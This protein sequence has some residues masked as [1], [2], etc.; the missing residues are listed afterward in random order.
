MI[1]FIGPANC[2]IP[3]T[4][5][6]PRALPASVLRP[7]RLLPPAPQRDGRSDDSRL[8][9]IGPLGDKLGR[10][11]GD[12]GPGGSGAAPQPGL[13]SAVVRPGASADPPQ[14][15]AG[16][17]AGLA[18][19]PGPPAAPAAA[20][21][22]AHRSAAPCRRRRPG[23]APPGPCS[24]ARA[25]AAGTRGLSALL[26]PLPRRDRAGRSPARCAPPRPRAGPASTRP[27]GRPRPCPPP[28]G[29]CTGA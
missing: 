11:A 5:S 22:R 21:A 19:Q 18:P 28:P 29:T 25:A 26:P 8:L 24:A 6:A 13:G 4:T 15:G 20:R 23:D 1:S 27:R 17:G 2:V 10:I 16:R 12:K 14:Q 3:D 9:A 7:A